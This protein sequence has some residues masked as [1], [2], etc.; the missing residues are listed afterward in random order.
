MRVHPRALQP[1]LRRRPAWVCTLLV[2]MR[3]R[4]SFVEVC[5][6]TATTMLNSQTFKPNGSPH[7]H[8]K[9]ETQKPRSSLEREAQIHRTAGEEASPWPG[10]AFALTSFPS[11]KASSASAP[12]GPA[13]TAT[14]HTSAGG[15]DLLLRNSGLRGLC[16]A[17]WH[18]LG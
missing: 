2:P 15:G 6:V 7:V 17:S 13:V 1:G 5:L 3:G 8:I 12:V 18:P 16:P 9:G 4:D 10:D 11:V 14:G